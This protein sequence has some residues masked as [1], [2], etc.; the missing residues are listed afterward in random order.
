MNILVLC[1]SPHKNGTT[2]ALAD[3]FLSGVDTGRHRVEKVILA[4]K[5][6]APC[7]GCEYCRSH[8]GSCIRRDDMDKLIPSVLAA[9]LIVEYVDSDHLTIM[10]VPEFGGIFFRRI[11]NDLKK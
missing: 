7:M 6:I 2:N 5:K 11:D 3:A 4:D 9:D 10:S 8:G 1:G